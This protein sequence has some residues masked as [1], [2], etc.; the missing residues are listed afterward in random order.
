[1]K[2]EALVL[3]GNTTSFQL[4]SKWADYLLS[5]RPIL[6]IRQTTD[7][8]GLDFLK[9]SSLVM[10]VL[11]EKNNWEQQAL[12]FLESCRHRQAEKDELEK[13]ERYFAPATIA[14]AYEDLLLRNTTR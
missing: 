2:M 11:T 5:G 3:L 8:P 7:D 14:A 9:G 10:S 6:H 4:P 12:A 13:W 1:Q